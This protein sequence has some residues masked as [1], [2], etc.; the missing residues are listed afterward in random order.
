VCSGVSSPTSVNS[1]MARGKPCDPRSLN[2]ARPS[3]ASAYGLSYTAMGLRAAGRLMN[4]WRILAHITGTV[5]QE[6]LLRNAYLAAENRF[7][8]I[9]LR[10]SRP[11]PR[12]LG[13][14]RVSHANSHR[15]PP[16][17][18]RARDLCSFDQDSISCRRLSTFSR[19]IR[20][21][22]FFSSSFSASLILL[23]RR[24]AEK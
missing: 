6:L 10:S 13:S 7:L 17:R 12:S 11:A 20:Q 14:K 21:I 24:D 1:L 5:D 3:V 22:R 15:C 9:R 8:K 18:D 23:L 16:P 2:L 4:W 19:S